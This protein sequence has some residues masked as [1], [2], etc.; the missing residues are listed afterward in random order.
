MCE[1]HERML[2]V[3]PRPEPTWAL[4]VMALA[5]VWAVTVLVAPLREPG[6]SWNAAYAALSMV[7]NLAG[8]AILA[9]AARNCTRLWKVSQGQ[10]SWA[11]VATTASVSLFS[12]VVATGPMTIG[13]WHFESLIPATLALY[14][15][16]VLV[17]EVKTRIALAKAS[18]GSR[19][20]ESMRR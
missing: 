6:A 8:V 15:A 5:Q 20:S 4:P 13:V 14:L 16:I 11:L 7:S 12:A 9:L 17:R 10:A 18:G 19:E 2:S 1:S 3:K